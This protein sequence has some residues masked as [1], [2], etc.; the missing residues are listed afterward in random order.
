VSE[1]PTHFGSPFAFNTEG[2]ANVVIQ[3]TPPNILANTF[4]VCVCP[5]GF[6]EDLPE[7]G[8]P[9]L[10]FQTVPLQLT[11]LEE[12]VNRWEPRANP[13]LTERAAALTTQA[14]R[15]LTMEVGGE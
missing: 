14:E 2:A 6:R 11:G 9:Q 12:A 5:E 7:F 10:E 13:Q 3:A 8:I 15:T 4:N 1:T